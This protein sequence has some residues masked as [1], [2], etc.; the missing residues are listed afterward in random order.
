[1]YRDNI[2]KLYFISL[3]IVDFCYDITIGMAKVN[4]EKPTLKHIKDGIPVS[5][6]IYIRRI[7]VSSIP[8]HDEKASAAWLQ[9]LYREKVLIFSH[10]LIK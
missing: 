3:K 7:P 10:Y 8:T 5:F 2:F 4:G 1:M 6:E 9:Q